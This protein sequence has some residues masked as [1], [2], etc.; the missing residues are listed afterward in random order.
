MTEHEASFECLCL[1]FCFSCGRC[2]TE[3][4]NEIANFGSWSSDCH[5]LYHEECGPIDE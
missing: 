5:V 4:C 3:E 1:H 2:L